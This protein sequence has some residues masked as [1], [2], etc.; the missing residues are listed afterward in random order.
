MQC[1]LCKKIYNDPEE[2]KGYPGERFGYPEVSLYFCLNCFDYIQSGFDDNLEDI[3]FSK[4]ELNF[5][6]IPKDISSLLSEYVIGQIHAKKVLSVAVYN[7]YKRL[8]DTNEKNIEIQK[9]NILLVGSTGSGKTYLAQTLSRILDVPFS[10]S[11]ATSLTE[12]GYVGEDVENILLS[13]YQAADG[14][15]EKTEKGIIYIDEIDKIA[16]KSANPSL[17]K[18]LGEG[19]QQSL[20]KILEG[21]VVNVPRK[22][23]RK[24]PEQDFLQ[25][26]TTGILF[27]LGGAFEGLDILIDQRVNDKT[28]GFD[29]ISSK[30]LD[31]FDEIKVET[32]DIL[33]FGFIP[34]FV[35]RIASIVSLKKLSQSDLLKIL[36]EPK[37]SLVKQY[38]RLFE[39]D[40]VK[41]VFKES[42]LNYIAEQALNEK[43][44]ARALKS[45]LESLLL[46]VM[47]EIPSIDNVS[48]CIVKFDKKNN[49]NIVE[50]ISD[51]GEKIK[52]F[53]TKKV[54]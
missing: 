29:N 33:N 37:N 35:G 52:S 1:T 49:K 14:D 23:G 3:T 45:I 40:N 51:E 44:G 13:L 46:D 24:H 53:M 9:S 4:P 43:N 11:D 32:Q 7:H 36:K 16:R 20:L 26:D 50:L 19:T 5:T 42:S 31:S 15:I 22:G 47:F 30:R 34:E 12:A 39:I 2:I 17:T 6:K 38:Q 18:E 10:I 25:I 41:L 27:I 28:I 54:A 21:S 48:E 8:K